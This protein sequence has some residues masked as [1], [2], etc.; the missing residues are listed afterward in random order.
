MDC[1][2]PGFPF[3]YQLPELTQTHVHRVSDT[4]EPFRPLLSPAPPAFDLS[5]RQ[6]LFQ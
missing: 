2:G 4:I 6:G 3:H 1:S 5:Q